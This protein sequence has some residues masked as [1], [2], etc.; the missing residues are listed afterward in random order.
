MHRFFR[1]AVSLIQVQDQRHRIELR[2]QR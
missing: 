1:K 2:R